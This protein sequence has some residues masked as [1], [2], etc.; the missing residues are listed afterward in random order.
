MKTTVCLALI[1]FAAICSITVPKECMAF[2]FGFAGSVGTGKLEATEGS[3]YGDDIRTRYDQSRRS[4][5]A[6]YDTNVGR[7]AIFNYRLGVSYQTMKA[8]SSTG[9]FD[10]EGI[11]FENDFGFS[12][13]RNERV[14]FWAGPEVKVEFLEGSE[15]YAD[16]KDHANVWSLGLGP[17]VGVNYRLNDDVS[18]V[19][20]GGFL[21]QTGLRFFSEWDEQYGFV[22]M[23]LIFNLGRDRAGYSEQ[24]SKTADQ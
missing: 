24:A 9:R 4:I 22:N 1:A 19:V 21:F 18:F 6:I 11:G 8:S 5:G 23:G 3:M 17:V 20:K 16:Y 10:L 12:L 15:T 7:D 2:G 14:R 13:V